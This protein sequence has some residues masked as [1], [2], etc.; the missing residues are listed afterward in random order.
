MTAP[1]TS[2]DVDTTAAARVE[3]A[4]PE[5]TR[6]HHG[7]GRLLLAIAMVLILAIG[8][9]LDSVT[10]SIHTH[11]AVVTAAPAPVSEPAARDDFARPDSAAGLGLAPSGQRWHT[12]GVWGITNGRARVVRAAPTAS[13]A[14]VTVGI[15]HGRIEVTADTMAPG[16][17]LAFRCRGALNCFRVEAVPSLGTWNVVKVVR[18]REHLLGNL[19]TVPVASGTR[20]AVELT[21]HRITGLV[22]GK[23]TRHFDDTD[24]AGEAGAGLSLR[25]PAGAAAARWSEF[26]TAPTPGPGIVAPRATA[27]GDDFGR[28]DAAT[29]VDASTPAWRAVAGD[30]GVRDGRAVLLTPAAAGPSLALV[31]A[32]GSDG[33][34]QLTL[35]RPQQGAGLAFRCRDADHCW[36]LEIVL[37]LGSWS[38]SKVV[39]GRVVV[40]APLGLLPIAPATTVA[41]RLQGAQ[42]DIFVDGRHVKTLHDDYLEHERGVGLVVDQHPFSAFTEWS[43]LLVGGVQS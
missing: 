19:G 32:P 29:L 31:D 30:F 26:R 2:M 10:S 22:D 13:L 15:L 3:R 33:T 7:D 1:T 8:L 27:I 36:R 20:V 39:D 16:L 40:E 14:L 23:V 17:G 25:E 24:L 21:A 42:I 18:G 38:V 9:L 5:E 41:V 12:I 11:R 37:G 4:E 35:W 43:Q 34:V 6:A 28:A